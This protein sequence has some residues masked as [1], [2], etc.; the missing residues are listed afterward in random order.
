MSAY[1]EEYS[2]ALYGYWR[3]SASWRVRTVLN[4][5]NIPYEYRAVNL[6][7]GE[8]VSDQTQYFSYD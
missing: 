1:A 2:F 6:L 4:L 8:Q 7:K 5:Y 3:S